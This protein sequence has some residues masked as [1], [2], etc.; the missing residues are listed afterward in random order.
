METRLSFEDAAGCATP[1]LAVFAVDIAAGK[2]VQP[3]PALLSTSDA[4]TNAAAKILAGGEF[5]ATPCECL[6]LH[7]PTG[8]KAERL[9]IVGLGKA[10]TLSVDEVRKGAGV[11]VRAL[12]T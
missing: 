3:L 1:L 12:K 6:L 10:K 5:K 8:L 4:V 11:A 9:L 2:E 7:N